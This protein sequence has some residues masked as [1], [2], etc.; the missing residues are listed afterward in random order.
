MDSGN[1]IKNSNVSAGGTFQAGKNNK[2]KGSTIGLD[3][4]LLD[5]TSKNSTVAPTGTTTEGSFDD[6][7]GGSNIADTGN[8]TAGSDDKI[9]RSTI[10][11]NTKLSSGDT[12][13]GSTI[14]LLL[15]I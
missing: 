9:R 11:G 10:S 8:F 6:I 12:V 2:V 1:T 7:T 4:G 13:K 5:F 15:L 14:G 3:L